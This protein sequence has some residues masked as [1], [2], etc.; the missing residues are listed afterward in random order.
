MYGRDGCGGDGG[1]GVCNFQFYCSVPS[2]I[3]TNY[4]TRDWR[5]LAK[6]VSKSKIF[7][8]PKHK[9][10]LTISQGYTD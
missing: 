10:Y 8:L 1:D 5:L 4:S 3:K 6:Y 2:Q 9:F 7:W